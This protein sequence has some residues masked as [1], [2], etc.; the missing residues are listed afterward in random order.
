MIEQPLSCFYSVI[1]LL[2]VLITNNSQGGDKW[3]GCYQ[4]KSTFSCVSQLVIRSSLTS[5]FLSIS[6]SRQDYSTC[7]CMVKV[8]HMKPVCIP[9]SISQDPRFIINAHFELRSVETS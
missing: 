1:L 8:A 4:I 2:T 6:G 5:I 3:D 9:S 7:A